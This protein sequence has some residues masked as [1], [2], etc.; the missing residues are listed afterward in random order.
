MKKPFGILLIIVLIG[1]ITACGNNTVSSTD[2]TIDKSKNALPENFIML[3]AGEWPRNEYT[4]SIPQPE[5]GKVSQ[6]WID[7]DTHRCYIDMTG[8]SSEVM[9]NWYNSLLDSG[10]TEIGKVAEEIKGQ[11]YISTNALLKKDGVYISMTHLSTDK[12]NLGLS[13]TREK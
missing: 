13:I 1:L 2:D 7:P 8:V 11:N 3:D 10:F 9:E 6:G 12:G 5:S 4:A